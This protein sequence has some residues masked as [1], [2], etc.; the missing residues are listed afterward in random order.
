MDYEEINL[1]D[2]REF[3]IYYLIEEEEDDLGNDNDDSC[4]S[5]VVNVLIELNIFN[6]FFVNKRKSRKRDSAVLF[7]IFFEDLIELDFVGVFKEKYSEKFW[8]CVFID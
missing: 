3:V 7:D 6:Y 4:N 8:W 2:L 5:V 1:N